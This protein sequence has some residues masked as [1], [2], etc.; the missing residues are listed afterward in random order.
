MLRIIKTYQLIIILTIGYHGLL[1]QDDM[2]FSQFKWINSYL[3][4]AMAGY[5]EDG[6]LDFSMIY[7]DQSFTVSPN[8][9]RTLMAQVQ[10][11]FQK[12][13]QGIFGISA[14]LSS[15]RAGAGQ[16]RSDQLG[17]SGSYKFKL[18]ES[19]HHFST[20]IQLFWI[21][22]KYGDLNAFILEEELQQGVNTETILNESF[23]YPDANVG[24]VHEWIINKRSGLLTGLSI[25][26]FNN[27]LQ[28]NSAEVIDK[29]PLRINIFS[30]FTR[31][32]GTG[33]T[34]I[35]RVHFQRSSVY[36]SLQFQ[37]MLRFKPDHRSPYTFDFGMGWRV[38][39]AF[40][41]IFGVKY[42]SWKIGLAYDNNTSGLR[43][44]SGNVS[45]LEIGINYA[46]TRHK[47]I[48]EPKEIIPVIP[49]EIRPTPVKVILD[50]PSDIPPG[51]IRISIIEKDSLTTDTI[52]EHW[53]LIH[54][55]HPDF[56]T[57]YIFKVPGYYPDT[58]RLIPGDQIPGLE[59]LHTFYPEKILEKAPQAPVTETPIDKP[60]EIVEE[61]IYMEE[62][63]ILENIFYDFDDDK[64]LEESED[65]LTHL[66]ELLN[67]HADMVIELS[68]HT[69]VR[70]SDTYN[71]ELSQRRADAAT[72][73]L[74]MRGIN[75]DRVVSKGYGETRLINH[76]DDGV[77][78]SE[79]LHRKNRRTEFKIIAGPTSVR[80]RVSKKTK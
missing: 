76:C 69:D 41:L 11:N 62:P 57:D 38:D 4:P 54:E 27:K 25:Q 31:A 1:A 58:L 7:R 37:T 23:S 65:E 61:I 21:Q 44:A 32:L 77:P 72:K 73:W 51:E 22:R 48:N 36:Q 3:N 15:D 46:Y 40:Q 70:G 28:E 75:P 20:G 66:L 30:Q 42:K 9:Y 8:P 63:I 55:A 59:F 33:L 80:Y 6:N 43:A 45:A 67:Q 64:I 10:S 47:K 71:I 34:L 35:P 13:G 60:E 16:L 50:K 5:I 78:C 19:G 52:V 14:L 79:V 24:I 49:N 2:H 68:S 29:Y 39:D 18:Y 12:P 53:P 74:F 56:P 26:H 17:I